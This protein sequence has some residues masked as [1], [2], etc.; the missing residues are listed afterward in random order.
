MGR[1]YTATM[2]DLKTEDNL[3]TFTFTACEYPIKEAIISC[4]QGLQGSDPRDLV[5]WYRESDLGIRSLQKIVLGKGQD[6]FKASLSCPFFKNQASR[7]LVPRK[8][9]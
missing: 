5:P 4:P 3:A 2:M 1:S 9:F 6:I 8:L 7:D